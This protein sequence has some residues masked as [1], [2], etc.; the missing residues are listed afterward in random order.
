MIGNRLVNVAT[1]Q[2][3]ASSQT[4]NVHLWEVKS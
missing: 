1:R 3:M 4:W 2:A